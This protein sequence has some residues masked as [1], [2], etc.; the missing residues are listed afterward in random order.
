M[1][2]TSKP[3]QCS[4]EDSAHAECWPHWVNVS[5]PI[6][7]VLVWLV[8]LVIMFVTWPGKGTSENGHSQQQ[9]DERYSIRRFKDY[10]RQKNHNSEMN[11][12]TSV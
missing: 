6:I 8:V 1:E 5:V 11:R 2:T 12:I 10:T 4:G 7:C 3:L 9:V